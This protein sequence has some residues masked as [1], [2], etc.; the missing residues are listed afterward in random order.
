MGKWGE[1]SKIPKEAEG[2]AL[3]AFCKWSVAS[4]REGNGGIIHAEFA[5]RTQIFQAEKVLR[6]FG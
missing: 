1:K 3:E 6:A 4:V 2:V 5:T